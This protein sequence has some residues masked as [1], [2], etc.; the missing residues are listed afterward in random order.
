[1]LKK[2]VELERFE[3]RHQK[4]GCL[5]DVPLEDFSDEALFTGHEVRAMIARARAES[6]RRR[7]RGHQRPDGPGHTTQGDALT[8]PSK[9]PRIEPSGTRLEDSS[10]RAHSALRPGRHFW[11]PGRKTFQDLP[12]FI[13]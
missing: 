5:M 2:A 12:C 7:R 1:M 11:Q 3:S 9:D 6:S 13:F 8:E 10:L 4:R